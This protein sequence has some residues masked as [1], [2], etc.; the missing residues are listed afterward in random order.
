M[1]II[2]LKELIPML[3]LGCNPD[4][5]MILALAQAVNAPWVVA[6]QR[7]GELEKPG[8]LSALDPPES[9]ADKVQM[10][11]QIRVLE[12]TSAA[13]S[14][15]AKLTESCGAAGLLESIEV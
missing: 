13:V 10:F 3:F 7:Y 12:V 5:D 1:I 11:H 2:S 14:R 15:C 4:P 9:L 8:L 6:V